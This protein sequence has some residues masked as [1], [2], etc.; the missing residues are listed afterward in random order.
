M[1]CLTNALLAQ[2]YRKLLSADWLDLVQE[3]DTSPSMLGMME[4]IEAKLAIFNL[5]LG[6]RVDEA[7][8]GVLPRARA[9]LQEVK[10]LVGK[11]LVGYRLFVAQKRDRT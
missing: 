9:V 6:Q 1:L 11:G 8:A 7:L 10:A 5:A 4:G 2:G 3:E